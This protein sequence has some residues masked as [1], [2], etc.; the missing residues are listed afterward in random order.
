MIQPN[1]DEDSEND[2][3][4]NQDKSQNEDE[5]EQDAPVAPAKKKRA[6]LGV[7]PREFIQFNEVHRWGRSDSTNEGILVVFIRRHL[8]GCNRKADIQH[9]PGKHIEFGQQNRSFPSA[10]R[11]MSYLMSGKNC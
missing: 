8:D 7:G 5:S 1:Q 6:V 9:L 10:A 3:E 2:G 4:D 11:S